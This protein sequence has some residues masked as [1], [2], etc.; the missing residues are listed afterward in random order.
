VLPVAR[1]GAAVGVRAIFAQAT[2]AGAHVVAAMGSTFV[3]LGQF[4][5]L[6]LFGTLACSLGPALVLAPFVLC[7]SLLTGSIGLVA[8]ALSGWRL[9]QQVKSSRMSVEA[10]LG[11]LRGLGPVCA[12][13]AEIRA[14][15]VQFLRWSPLATALAVWIGGPRWVE[16]V[17]A[18]AFQHSTPNRAHTDFTSRRSKFTVVDEDGSAS[19]DEDD[20]HS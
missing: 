2:F 9:S 15:L 7:A 4:H 5:P 14:S 17:P 1:E 3:S 10:A 16:S 8:G 18:S 19:D 12:T 6:A 11:G 20:G 13:L